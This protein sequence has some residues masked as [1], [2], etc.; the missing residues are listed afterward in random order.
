MI[1]PVCKKKI[2][3]N[4]VKCPYCNARTGLL[5]PECHTVN[6]LSDLKCKK[7]GK[8]LLKRCLNCGS[9]NY[10]NA[11]KCRK[12]GTAFKI[13]ADEFL[14]YNPNLVSQKSA[15]NILVKGILSADKK[16]FSL[17]GEKG[18]GKSVVLKSVMQ[19][20]KDFAWIYGK[21]T[22]V[23]QLTAGGFIQDVLLNMFRLPN[24]CLNSLQF[25]KDCFEFFKNEFPE[26]SVSE[27]N[28]LLNFLYPEKEGI[29]EDII[30][31]KSKTYEFL[32]KIFDRFTAASKFVIAVDNFDFIDGFSYEF[33]SKYIQKSDVLKNLKF[34]LV[35]SE[36]KPA[37]GYFYLQTDNNQNIYLD[38]GLADLEFRQV[39]MILEQKKKRFDDYIVPPRNVV[40]E[41]YKAGSGNPAYISHAL[42]YYYDCIKC[43][44]EFELAATFKGLLELRLALLAKYNPQAYNVLLCSSVIGDK[45]NTNLIREI[46]EI[47]NKTFKRILIYLKKM[48]FIIPVNDIYCE[49]SSLLLWETIVRTT[50]NDKNYNDINEKV[51]NT[52]MGFTLNSRSVL[53]IIAQNIKQPKLALDIWSSIT[54]L[55]TYIGDVNLYAIAQKQSLALINEFDENDTLKIR[56]NISERLGKLLA[57]SNPAEAMTYLPDAVSNAKAIGDSAKE[58]ELLAYLAS[59]CRATG[60]YFGEVECVDSVLEKINPDDELN[61]ALLKTTKL[62]ALLSIGNCGQVINMIDNEI[63]PVLDKYFSRRQSSKDSRVNLVYETWVKTYLVLANALILQGN[64]RAFEILTILFDIIERNQ[65]QNELFVCDCKLSLAFANTMKGNFTSSEQMLEDIL[66]TYTNLDNVAVIRWNFINIINCFMQKRYYGIQQDLFKVVTFANNAGD[67][68]TK[69]ILKTLLGKVFKDNDNSKQAMEIY[70]DQIAYFAKEKM[71]LGALLTWYLIADAA[72]IT[73]GP[74]NA[75]EIAQQALEVAQNPKIDN[76]IF[77]ILLKTVIAKC[78]MTTSDYETAKINLESAIILARKFNLKDLLSRLY[79]LY[80]K[81]FQEIG[82]IK[83]EKQKEY[84]MG[85]QELYAHAQEIIEQTKNRYLYGELKKAKDVLKSFCKLNNISL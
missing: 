44:K 78:A 2:N 48:N 22:P 75:M 11:D 55:C 42:D 27:I 7:C 68:F 6:S 50:K 83:S 21:C 15:K 52:L 54:R 69:N 34:L 32:N 80:G 85:A 70:R 73:E 71:A 16:I 57:N 24:F 20:L 56:Y 79:I 66:K 33:L 12:C 59:C 47:D 49:F 51:F 37:Q 63:M 77:T 31:C 5:C 36:H 1:C 62:N 19:E 58:I 39:S 76:Y 81:Y 13:S 30:T 65:I 23:T 35:Y 61:I 84:L 3:E 10:P 74:Q 60:K 17:S 72:L 25:K 46:F 4:T 67:N 8:E 64:D 82:L 9:V 28:E 38:V 18:S 53:A 26:L 14:S 45:I 43:G 29:F 41:I 40:F